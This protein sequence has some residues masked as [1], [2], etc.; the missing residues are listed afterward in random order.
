MLVTLVVEKEDFLILHG[1]WW[2][3]VRALHVCHTHLDII[4]CTTTRRGRVG[5][6]NLN[7]G[8]EKQALEIS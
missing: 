2:Q 5:F 6:I 7:H 3:E 8:G 4:H 1:K